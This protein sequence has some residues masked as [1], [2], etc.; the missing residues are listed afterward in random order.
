[1][2][3]F[4]RAVGIFFLV[5]HISKSLKG[6]KEVKYTLFCRGFIFISG[7]CGRKKIYIQENVLNLN[8]YLNKQLAGQFVLLVAGNFF[9]SLSLERQH[10]V[11]RL[12]AEPT[13]YRF[14]IYCDFSI[15]EQ[16][17]VV[18]SKSFVFLGSKKKR[19]GNKFWEEF[20]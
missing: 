1:M 4:K 2:I 5:S 17:S 15:G 18:F 20:L 9:F 7:G 16:I 14:L 3:R 19:T 8:K 13:F 11:M 6:F 10:L 12:F